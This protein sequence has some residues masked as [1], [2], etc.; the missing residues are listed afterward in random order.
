MVQRRGKSE[1]PRAL[2]E[3]LWHRFSQA[4][5]AAFTIR[6]STSMPDALSAS[7]ST[8]N[9]MAHSPPFSHALTTALRAVT[10]KE[11]SRA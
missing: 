5:T 7:M 3:R 10:S 4:L 2:A 8:A 1:K 11:T 6:A 9:A